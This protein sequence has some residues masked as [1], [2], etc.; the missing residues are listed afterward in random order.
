MCVHLGEHPGNVWISL[1][2]ERYDNRE[3]ISPSPPSTILSLTQSVTKS[4]YSHSKD[5]SNDYLLLNAKTK[6]VVY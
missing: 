2:G 3:I 6:I 5:P 1:V 4:A